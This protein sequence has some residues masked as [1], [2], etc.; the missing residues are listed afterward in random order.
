MG[1]PVIKRVTPIFDSWSIFSIHVSGVPTIEKAS[2]ISGVTFENTS[3]Q[4]PFPIAA[5]ILF[6]DSICMLCLCKTDS[7]LPATM[8]ATTGVAAFNAF[9]GSFEAEKAV[10]ATTSTSPIFLPAF[11][12]PSLMCSIA[13]SKSFGFEALI[14]TPS[15]ISAANDNILGPWAPM[16]TGIGSATLKFSLAPAILNTLPS[17]LTASPTVSPRINW[18]VSLTAFK[19]F[20]LS[21]LRRSK[22]VLSPVP[23]PQ[24]TRPGA[25][26]LSEAM[27]C[28]VI[29]G[30]IR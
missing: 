25:I 19:G 24:T 18:T 23:S 13:L 1:E 3:P 4:S 27:D 30:W 9:L 26:S 5:L 22:V 16:K 20:T 28:A 12:I 10:A 21:M 7:G 11:S 8:K 15:P 6:A 29:T 2:N 17:N 14:R